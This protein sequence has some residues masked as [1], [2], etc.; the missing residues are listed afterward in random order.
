VIVVPLPYARSTLRLL[1]ET[2]STPPLSAK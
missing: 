1:K 2:C